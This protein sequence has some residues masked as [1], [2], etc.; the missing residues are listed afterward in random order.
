MAAYGRDSIESRP[1]TTTLASLR[2]SLDQGAGDECPG[3]PAA[4]VPGTDVGM[5]WGA[6]L[7]VTRPNALASLGHVHVTNHRPLRQRL[8]QSL[9][10][11]I[12]HDVQIRAFG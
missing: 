4:A 11:A 2:R 12:D 6:Q 5:N 10:R 8:R 3:G 9:R 1:Q 7:W